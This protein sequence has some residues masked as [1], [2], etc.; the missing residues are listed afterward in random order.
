MFAQT[1]HIP[2]WQFRP[3][4]LSEERRA[5]LT[6]SPAF[7]VVVKTISDE[8]REI[9]AQLV[10]G[11]RE[12]LGKERFQILFAVQSRTVD[13]FFNGSKGLR[14]Q[15]FLDP[16]LGNSANRFA[17]DALLPKILEAVKR[18]NLSILQV[19]KSLRLPSAKIWISEEESTLDM[20]ARQMERITT[21][22]VT[23]WVNASRTVKAARLG[24]QAPQGNR[25]LIFGAWLD[26]EGH[27]F[28]VPSKIHRAERIHQYGFD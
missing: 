28:L 17:I 13:V 4:K 5:W 26:L 19:E 25:L 7:D 21:L 12:A 15:Y 20:D 22:D 23:R 14:A 27:E 11:E 3:N 2:Q 10:P 1:I 24:V 6:H 18:S 8:F 9:R 16:Y